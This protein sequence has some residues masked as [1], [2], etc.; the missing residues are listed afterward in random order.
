MKVQIVP[1]QAVPSQV[2]TITLA[3][4]ACVIK[5]YTRAHYGLFLDLTVDQSVI[6][7]GVLCQNRNR[8]VRSAY[9][10]FAGDLV[11]LDSQGSGD[12]VYAGL[13]RRFCLAYLGLVDIA[14]LDMAA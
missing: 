10:G 3:N 2:V 8:I 4:Q 13:G 9:L 14:T 6:L 1:L 5:V 11:F 7:T 12:P